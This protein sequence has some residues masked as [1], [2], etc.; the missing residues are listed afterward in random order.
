MATRIM[1]RVGDIYRTKE[2]AGGIRYLQ[3]VAIDLLDLN[4]DVIV[5]FEPSTKYDGPPELLVDSGVEFY[6]HTVVSQ[7]IREGLWQKTG[8]EEVRV[9]ITKL[10]FK[11][12]HGMDEAEAVAFVGH[13]VAPPIPYPHWTVWS[14]GDPEERYVPS[15]EGMSIQAERGGVFPASDVVYRIEHGQSEFRS[16]W[17]Q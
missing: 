7:G 11:A 15:G 6:T 9:D 10:L 12:Y 4:S 2:L 13:E 14:P 3:L 8:K 17:A 16:N 1:T 5:V